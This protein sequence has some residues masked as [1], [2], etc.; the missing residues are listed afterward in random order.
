L[1]ARQN[2]LAEDVRTLSAHIRSFVSTDSRED[3][4]QARRASCNSTPVEL[5]GGT[6]FEADRAADVETLI[7][8][9]ASARAH[10]SAADGGTG[11]PAS[12]ERA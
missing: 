2:A 1:L 3:A 8:R 10:A 7:E 11:G 12:D 4:A 9:S 5:R 6:R